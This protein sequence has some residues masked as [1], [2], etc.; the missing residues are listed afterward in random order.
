MILNFTW[1]LM[2]FLIIAQA[3][4]TYFLLLM[5]G[6]LE[7]SENPLTFLYYN[8][9]VVS[10]VGFGDFSPVSSAGKMIVAL[11]Q[12]PSGLIVFASFIGKTT[13]FFID[14]TRK[15]MYGTN[16]YSNFKEHI[17]LISWD[18]KST[19]H[20]LKLILGD[21]KRKKRKILLCVTKEMLNPFPDHDN[22]YFAK[23]RSF[24]DT[25]E[26]NRI[27]LKFSDR[28][29]VN[30]ETDDETLAIALSIAAF[31]NHSANISAHF[32]DKEKANLLKI[33]CPHVESSTDMSTEMMVRNIQ[34]PGTSSVAA[35]LLSTLS[36]ATLYCLQVP[37]LKD[38]VLFDTLFFKFKKEY[39]ITL[40]G[41][42][43]YK[44]GDDLQLEPPLNTLIK[45][46][47]FL[48]Y[49]AHERVI[50]EPSIWELTELD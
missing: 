22:V 3:V 10:T 25:E 12:I 47:N 8:M 38:P 49:I 13:Q 24:S 6:E 40:I 26:L 14:I 19:E 33:H 30:G 21:K 15:N 20:I 5:A 2:F 4:S 7:L 39:S 16:D 46:G 45:S 32:S 50:L 29:I 37:E 42:S 9:V 23:I 11:Y 48:Y 41:L 1:P 27:G 17:L 31:T 34:D 43:H 28:I 18:K 35:H 36:G 44:N